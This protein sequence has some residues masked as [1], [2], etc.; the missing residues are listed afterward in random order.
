MKPFKQS[1]IMMTVLLA[2]IILAACGAAAPSAPYDEGVSGSAGYAEAPA[3]VAPEAK[4][5]ADSGVAESAPANNVAT[6]LPTAAPLA[7]AVLDPAAQGQNSPV[8][9]SRMIIKNGEIRLLVADSEVALDRTTQIIGDLGGYIVSSRSWYQDWYGVNYKYISMTIG[10]PSDQ[11]ETALRRLRGLAVRVIDESAAGEDVTDQFVDLESEMKNLEATRNRIRS[12]LDQATTVEE[13][14]KVNQQLSEIEKQIEEIKG[15]M[16]YLS[17][18]AAF[19][20][21]NIN[22]EPELPEVTPTS[23]PTPTNSPTPRPTSTPTPWEPGKTFS[24]AGET[25]VDAYKWMIEVAIWIVV[26]VIPVLLP[27]ALIIWGLWKLSTRKSNKS[28][29]NTA[30]VEKMMKD[31]KKPE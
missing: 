3:A 30:H 11:F 8:T 22:I 20:T 5:M 24:A 31:D 25:V 7:P 15:R 26:V 9:S 13:A 2:V 4:S 1:L 21:I 18:R 19:S 16:N 6:S 10:V 23:T 14:L 17:N 27:F 28:A 29:T 12:F